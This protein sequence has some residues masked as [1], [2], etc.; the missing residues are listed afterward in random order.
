MD[1]KPLVSIRRLEE[2]LGRNRKD[3]S[4]I[5]AKAG[6]Y[7]RPFD[8]RQQNRGK[9]RH[10]ANPF[11]ELKEIQKRIQKNILS[12]YEFPPTMVGGVLRR[13][14]RHHA[15]FHRRQ[16]I[17]VTL[18]LRDCFMRID[19]R[20]V[21][22][23]YRD[24]FGCSSEIASILTK[25]TT[26]QGCL[27]QGAP[28]SSLL[29]NL[30]LLPLHDDIKKLCDQANLNMSFFVDDIA[31]SGDHALT[32]LEGVIRTIHKHGHAVKRKKI[33]RMY[34]CES[35]SVTGL[36]VNKS[37]SVSHKR[38]KEIV[39]TIL[40]LSKRTRI[41]SYEKASLLGKINHVKSI[42][43]KHGEKLEKLAQKRLPAIIVAGEKPDTSEKIPCYNIRKHRHIPV[44]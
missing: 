29:A 33:R 27:P 36:T 42:N 13:D 34:G 7:Y 18:D 22:R 24:H 32:V 38:R 31:I 14:M 2:L 8:V 6:R 19:D 15:Q 5:A 10:I 20:K 35:Q 25:L 11:G 26:F 44:K 28:T 23:S 43:R 39:R 41:T 16:P 40:E 21:F 9:I 1:G 17:V 37:I 3:I 12:S 4:N 30:S